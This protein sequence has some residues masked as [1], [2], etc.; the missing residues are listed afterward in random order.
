MEVLKSLK[1]VACSHQS[2]GDV[3]SARA[4]EE[5]AVHRADAAAVAGRGERGKGERGARSH[6]LTVMVNG[7]VDT[8]KK[9]PRVDL[10]R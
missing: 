4:T 10:E 8:S 1:V 2:D 6:A 9:L 3:G 5:Q 7:A